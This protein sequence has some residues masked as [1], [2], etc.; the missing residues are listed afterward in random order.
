M[1]RTNKDVELSE[2]LRQQIE[3]R[4]GDRGKFRLLEEA[5]GIPASRWKNFFYKKQEAT[6]PLIKFWTTK[7]P[8]DE[9]WVL[10]GVKR[11]SK[12]NFPFLTSPPTRWQGQTMGDRLNWVIAEW[13]SPKGDSLFAYLQER[14]KDEIAAEEWKAVFLG[15]AQP[16]AEMIALVCSSRP[17]FT[18][19][20]LLGSVMSKIEVDP[21]DNASIQRWKDFQSQE[22][23]TLQKLI[24]KSREKE[25]QK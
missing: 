3:H 15:K 16:T 5:S 12:E 13:A 6:S 10:E 20:V 14:S 2:R 23:N 22:W 4:F 7:F 11:P 9:S 1:T 24:L 25:Q 8:E 17:H 19:W 21:T 18:Q